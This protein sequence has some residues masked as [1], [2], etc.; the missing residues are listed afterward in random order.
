VNQETDGKSKIKIFTVGEAE[1]ITP[2]IIRF[3]IFKSYLFRMLEIEVLI[4]YPMLR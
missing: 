4:L 1:V 3:P 2:R